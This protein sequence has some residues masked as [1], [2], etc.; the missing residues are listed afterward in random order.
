[1]AIPWW[2]CT[3]KKCRWLQH[4]QMAWSKVLD[5]FCKMDVLHQSTSIYITTKNHNHIHNIILSLIYTK[6]IIINTSSTA[7]G[8]G[9]S[10]KNRKPIGEVRCCEAGM[11]ERI[12]WWTER[13]LRSPLFLSLSLTIYLPTDLS[14]YLS[15]YLSLSISVSVWLSICLSV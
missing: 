2:I 5:F 13:C 14:M 15:I 9:G 12:H 3:H 1:M 8:G 11:A 6:I 4:V 7:Q 10:F